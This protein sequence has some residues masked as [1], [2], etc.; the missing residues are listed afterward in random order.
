MR[1][2]GE[3]QCMPPKFWA[4]VKYVS[5]ELKYT[6]SD[7]GLVRM[8]SEDEIMN[9]LDANE[10]S[11]EYEIVRSV[12]KYSQARAELLNS[13]VKTN[14][15]D[16]DAAR[17]EY[18][19]LQSVHT[20][21]AYRCK[22]PMNKQSGDK[23]H[24]MYLTAIVN[25]LTEQTLRTYTPHIEGKYF[26]DDPTKYIYAVDANQCLVGTASRHMDG[27]YP[28]LV[29]PL[30]VWEIKEYYGTKTF[31]SRVADG[32]Y[33]TQ[34]DGYE[35]KKFEQYIGHRILHV[36]FVDDYFTWWVKG[37]SYLCR[38]VDILNEG[39]VDEII[40]G[41]EVLNRWPEVL[42]SVLDQ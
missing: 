36:L 13:T 29:N 22:I 40:I 4:L 17:R 37:K 23:Q 27:A 39:L 10:H 2:F 26:V 15:M 12:S 33:E 41:R 14:L 11:F 32:V 1:P 38:L 30:I 16:I 21:N 18:E 42:R 20:E 25:I 6:D 3:F 35:L 9:L 28:T 34:L 5:Q 7:T 24:V 8:Y 31:G 19:L